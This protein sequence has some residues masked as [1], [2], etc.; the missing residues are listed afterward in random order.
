MVGASNG[1]ESFSRIWMETH[2]T[3]VTAC[4]TGT[5]SCTVPNHL[6][7]PWQSF[8][9]VSYGSIVQHSDD[10]SQQRA[11]KLS[12]CLSILSTHKRTDKH[13][14]ASTHSRTHI[15]DWIFLMLRCLTN[16]NT[17][18]L[19]ASFFPHS[20]LPHARQTEAQF[21]KTKHLQDLNSGWAGRCPKARLRPV[22][23]AAPASLHQH[24]G[25]WHRSMLSKWLLRTGKTSVLFSS[26]LMYSWLHNLGSPEQSKDWCPLLKKVGGSNTKGLH[27]G[28]VFCGLSHYLSVYFAT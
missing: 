18:V 6:F 28:P 4:V 11:A 20:S 25:M 17:R 23:T 1:R 2:E 10:H 24:C 13:T 16:S 3:Y 27:G 5:K 15:K 14:R 21:L 8:S 19:K 26:V 12:T 9:Q 22:P 7:S